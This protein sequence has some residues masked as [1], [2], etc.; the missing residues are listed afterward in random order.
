MQLDDHY[1]FVINVSRLHTGQPSLFRSLWRWIYLFNSAVLA[2]R[3]SFVPSSGAFNSL[4]MTGPGLA[5]W[6]S[7]VAVTL[8]LTCSSLPF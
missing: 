6:C 8:S 5:L 7:N 3:S 4:G 1:G 2:R